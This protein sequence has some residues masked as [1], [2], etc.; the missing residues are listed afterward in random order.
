MDAATDI[1]RNGL[2][3]LAVR[4]I[5][6]HK[7]VS[8]PTVTKRSKS[9]SLSLVRRIFVAVIT[10]LRGGRDPAYRGGMMRPNRY[11]C[12]PKDYINLNPTWMRWMSWLRDWISY[13]DDDDDDVGVVLCDRACNRFGLSLHTFT[14]ENKSTECR[15]PVLLR[16]SK[17]RNF[18]VR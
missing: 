13:D 14:S 8:N 1:V 5:W 15:V 2:Q 7:T 9:N 4:E 3:L 12:T 17:F 11:L 18:V 6:G 16:V 10:S